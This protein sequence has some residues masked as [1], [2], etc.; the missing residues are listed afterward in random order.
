MPAA[1]AIQVQIDAAR[2]YQGLFVPALFQEFAIQVADAARIRP[3]E[4]VLDVACGTGVLAREAAQRTGSGGQVAG[5][6]PAAGMLAVA[7]QLSPEIE[8]KEGVAEQLP[9]PDRYFDVVVS[10]FGIMFFTDRRQALRDMLRV[11]KPGGRLLVAVWDTLDS[12]PAYG[13]ETAVIEKSAGRKAG[14]ALRA[15]FVLGDREQLASLLADADLADAAISTHRGTARYPGSR[16]MVEADLRGW[17]PLMGIT[18]TEAQIEHILGEAEQALIDY[19][20]E[21]GRMTF[22]LSAHFI[23][24]TRP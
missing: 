21:D 11:L 22:D 5:I 9:F 17:L 3:G 6:D 15:P 12:M 20:A 19:T 1:G 18:L 7:R 24:A 14:D 4:R 13:I 2:A 8:W 23:S 16:V 10:Q